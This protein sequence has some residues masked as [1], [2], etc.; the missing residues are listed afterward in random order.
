MHDDTSTHHKNKKKKTQDFDNTKDQM[1]QQNKINMK[2][3]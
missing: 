3:I 1:G 2:G